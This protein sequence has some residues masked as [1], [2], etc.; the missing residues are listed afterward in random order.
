M[1]AARKRL[2]MAMALLCLLAAV[3]VVGQTL[4]IETAVVLAA[5]SALGVLLI[6]GQRRHARAAQAATQRLRPEIQQLRSAVQQLQDQQVRDRKDASRWEWRIKQSVEELPRRTES[7]IRH[8]T[9]DVL[10]SLVNETV[11]GPLTSAAEEHQATAER[12]QEAARRSALTLEHLTDLA[13]LLDQAGIFHRS[14]YEAT[15]QRTFPDDTSARVHFVSVGMPTL[16][17]PHPLLRPDQLPEAVKE[18]YRA[19]DLPALLQFLQRPTALMPPLSNFFSPSLVEATEPETAEHPGGC[20]GWF[21][22]HVRDSDLLPS[23]QVHTRWGDFE[24]A[25]NQALTAHRRSWRVTE[26][27]WQRTW[28]EQAERAWNAAVHSNSPDSTAMTGTV[29]IIMLARQGSHAVTDAIAS[30]SAQQWQ[31]WELIL[32]TPEGAAPPA[33]PEPVVHDPRVTIQ[34]VAAGADAEML[35]AGLAHARGTWVAFLDSDTRWRPDFLHLMVQTMAPT[36]LSM[37]YC[38]GTVHRHDDVRYRAF[39]GG[40]DELLTENHIHLPGVVVPRSVITQV[41]GFDESLDVG[42]EYDLVLRLSRLGEPRYLP[43]LGFEVLE[44]PGQ[45]AEGPDDA[46]SQLIVLNRAWTR[47]PQGTDGSRVAGRVSVIIPTMDHAQ[48][49]IRAVRAVRATQEDADIEVLIVDNGS[50]LE[51]RLE[52]AGTFAGDPHVQIVPIHRNLNFGIGSNIGLARSTGEFVMFLN[53][54]TVVREG[55][56]PPL[57]QALEDD[58]VLAAQPVLR[59]PDDSIQTAGTVW[60]AADDLPVHFLAHHP[61]ED[62]REVDQHR[63]PAVTAAAMLLRAA[64]VLEVDGFDPRFRNGMEDVDLCLRLARA[65]HGAF[66]VVPSSVV[67]HDESRTPGR[68]VHQI[69]NRR[70]FLDRWRGQLPAPSREIFAAHHLRVD[71]VEHDTL[72]VPTPRP[73]V[74]RDRSGAPRRWGIRHAA[75]GGPDGD[76]WGDTAFAESLARALRTLGQEV[77]TYRHGPNADTTGVLDDVSLVLRGKDAVPRIPG[78]VNILWVISHPDEIADEELRQADLAYAASPLWAAARS[79]TAGRQVNPLL[80]CTDADFFHPAGQQPWPARPATFVGSVHPGRRRRVVADALA[81][82]VDLRVIGRGWHR[83]LPP[84]VWER[85]HIANDQLPGIYRSAFRVLADHWADMAEG[86][87]IQNRIFDAVACGA[88]VISD[89]VAGLHDV[90]GDAVA[91]YRTPQELARLCAPHSAHPAGDREARANLADH[92]RTTHSFAARAREL[93]AAVDAIASRSR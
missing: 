33:L 30:V 58:R 50:T 56:L 52:L 70:L 61:P 18:A 65:R 35:N 54:D 80:Q 81:A 55:W 86:G 38:A 6:L 32:L 29:S 76:L 40:I 79:Q 19:S 13:I 39:D 22:E 51:T 48:L 89:P 31:D 42:I 87:F 27:R 59:Y 36:T 23:R 74:V 77:V 1:T 43:F 44:K 57:V 37:A 3:L 88:P 24:T 41:D 62:A 17:G 16:S 78:A 9:R 85:E 28:D 75:T 46:V 26:A 69:A 20:L 8:E 10:E 66:R 64:D 72:E 15:Q 68:S 84:E 12:H 82:G 14:Y 53:N 34:P 91:V 49:T 7:L 63:F 83:T 11:V 60:V 47:A 92:V 73:I 21:L 90:F 67:T 71:R 25:I 45:D 4:G 93:V 2:V 5:V